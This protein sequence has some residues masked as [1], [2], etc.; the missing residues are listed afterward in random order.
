MTLPF[1]RP[2]GCSLQELASCK[3]RSPSR[4]TMEPVCPIWT[5]SR[6]RGPK[7]RSKAGAEQFS[8][9]PMPSW[10]TL[11]RRRQAGVRECS[12]ARRLRCDHSRA[13]DEPVRCTAMIAF[14]PVVDPAAAELQEST[15]SSAM[16]ALF[17]P[18]T[19]LSRNMQ[20]SAVPS[21]S[22]EK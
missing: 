22:V 10:S 21:T 4:Q 9:T 8:A 2:P 18:L 19:G 12:L 7:V 16:G 15:I 20:Y 3:H 14:I 6:L 5:S 17:T 11:T 1:F 13:S